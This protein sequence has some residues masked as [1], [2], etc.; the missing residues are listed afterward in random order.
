MVQGGPG[1]TVA[2]RR[3]GW[4]FGIEDTLQYLH[5]GDEFTAAC[6]GSWP[7]DA[8]DPDDIF[9]GPYFQTLD[10]ITGKVWSQRASCHTA[11][12]YALGTTQHFVCLCMP[13]CSH[14]VLRHAQL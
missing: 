11:G 6:Q 13:T 8:S 1:S 14:G 10:A 7:P 12:M 2:F 9:S 3:R 5:E 4:D